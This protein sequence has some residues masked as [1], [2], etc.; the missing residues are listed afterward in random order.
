MFAASSNRKAVNLRIAGAAFALQVV[1]AVI[2]LLVTEWIPLEV[3]ALLVMG[4]LAVTKTVVRHEHDRGLGESECL[5]GSFG[6]A[7][8]HPWDSARDVRGGWPP[9]LVRR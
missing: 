3:I 9:R 5:A 8:P 1:V 6:S 2:V 7:A 4:V